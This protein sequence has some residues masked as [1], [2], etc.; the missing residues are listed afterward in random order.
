MSE[1]KLTTILDVLGR[2][3]IGEKD[4]TKSNDSILA[5]KNPA[6]IHIVPDPAA[7]Q[8]RLQ[9]LPLFFKDFLADK[10]ANTLW[11][12]RKAN[13]TESEEIVYDFKVTAQYQQIFN[14]SPIII[15]KPAS[16]DAPVIKL[17]DDVK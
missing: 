5:L 17:F 13:I 7:N 16:N 15:P 10:E 3:I 9:I 2:T 8:L 6:I 11:Y 12:Y 4:E 1:I 14:P